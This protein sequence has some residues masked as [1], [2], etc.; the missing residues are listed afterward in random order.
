M[1]NN[2]LFY[3]GVTGVLLGGLTSCAVDACSFDS[4]YKIADPSRCDPVMAIDTGLTASPKRLSHITGGSMVIVDKKNS[5]AEVILRKAGVTLSLGTLDEAGVLERNVAAAELKAFTLGEIGLELQQAKISRKP[6]S[7]RIY[8]EPSLPANEQNKNW[9]AIAIGMDMGES[10]SAQPV[11]IGITSKPSV[12]VLKKIKMTTGGVIMQKTSEYSAD[13]SLTLQTA[14][15]FPFYYQEEN[16]GDN[17]T[18]FGQSKMG[19]IFSGVFS[20]SPP[21]RLT[22][23]YSISGSDVSQGI[24]KII[25]HKSVS[26]LCSDVAGKI[27]GAIVDGRLSFFEEQSLDKPIEMI[28]GANKNGSIATVKFGIGNLDG[29]Q[30]PDVAI[31]HDAKDAISVYTLKSNTLEW[32]PDL[33]AKLQ[34]KS[35]GVLRQNSPTAVRL[36]DIDRDGV[37]DVLI[38]DRER[39][40][41]LPND[42]TGDY[43]KSIELSA[44]G[45][46]ANALGPISAIAIGQLG[47][48]PK[49]AP[50]LALV[51]SQ[52][53]K[54]AVVLNQS[55]E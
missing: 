44:I 40:I 34:A 17:Y 51:S 23:L 35:A 8:A 15:R 52:D 20:A 1:F 43:E 42:G 11:M 46:G 41:I 31:W 21:S 50:S 19:I 39:L 16:A 29:D 10:E 48:N 6:M 28:H 22:M 14:N 53:K 33:S 3:F 4:E 26:Q 27:T 38:A 36:A 13:I 9:A 24:P 2:R 12:I 54:I 37:D 5:G 47:S 18:G 49:S 45:S 25:S 32:N 30:Y 55:T 7:I